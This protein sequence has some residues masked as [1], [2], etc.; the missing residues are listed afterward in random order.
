MAQPLQLPPS[1]LPAFQ[2]AS[3]LA[4]SRPYTDLETLLDV[5]YRCGT[6]NSL[7]RQKG[8]VCVTCGA[9]FVRSMLT[10][11][12][13]PLVEFKLEGGIGED[14]VMGLLG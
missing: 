5:C 4:H 7:L 9:E 12:Q 8:D 2:A 13:L 1:A 11:E 14:Q 3:L 10:Y 6:S